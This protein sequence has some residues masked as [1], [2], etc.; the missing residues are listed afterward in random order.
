MALAENHYAART[1]T[2]PL[3][4]LLGP[5]QTRPGSARPRPALLDPLLAPLLDPLLA[6]L[7]DPPCWTQ[8]RAYCTRHLPGPDS[9]LLDPVLAGAQ[10]RP[11][12][13]PALAGAQTWPY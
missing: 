8:T 4:A 12:P 10:T 5:A 9:F 3:P 13:A 1:R 11:L 7:L 2:R 6:P